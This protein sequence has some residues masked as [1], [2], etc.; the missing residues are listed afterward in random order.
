MAKKILFVGPTTGGGVAT[1]NNEV[2]AVFN[3]AGYRCLT[4][5]AQKLMKKFP[6]P[7]AYVLA[8]LHAVVLIIAHRPRVMYMQIAQT[9]YMHQSLFFVWAKLFRRET[10]AHFH[11]N[12]NLQQAVTPRHFQ[13]ILNSER[14]ID[15]MILLTEPCRRSLVDNGWTKETHVVPNFINAAELPDDFPPVRARKQILYLGRMDRLKGIF[16]IIETARLLPE[17]EFTFVGDFADEDLEREFAREL[18]A[19]PNARWLGSMWGREKYEVIARSRFLLL[20]TR[21]DEFPMILIEATI[22]GC[23]P[24]TSVI[25]SVSEIIQD[26]F[27]GFYIRPDDVEGIADKIRE[28]QARDDLQK[29]ADSGVGFAREHF[30]NVVVRDALLAIV[31]SERPVVR[32]E[33]SQ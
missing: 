31:E 16:E 29:I 14:F 27:N 2:A 33:G 10:V 19:T 4:V 9:G 1:I 7:V 26:G 3:Q 13:Q 24:L 5:D 21:R 30:T 20:P 11:A 23:I 32:A 12:A 6:A 15:K 8:Y 28:L 22:L 18:E 17:E 25:G